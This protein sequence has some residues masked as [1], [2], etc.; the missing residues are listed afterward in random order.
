MSCLLPAGT[1]DET[2]STESG[3]YRV[4]IYPVKPITQTHLIKILI[5]DVV[6]WAGTIAAS[7]LPTGDTPRDVAAQVLNATIQS[8]KL[9]S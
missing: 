7:L 4:I 3:L 1:I 8:V 6:F 5:G 2:F 9:P